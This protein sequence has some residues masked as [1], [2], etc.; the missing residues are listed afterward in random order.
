[1]IPVLVEIGILPRERTCSVCGV[2]CT[3]Q[4]YTQ[5][6]DGAVFRCRICRTRS[7]LRRGTFFDNSKLPLSS[8]MILLFCFV[9]GMSY[10]MHAYHI[11]LESPTKTG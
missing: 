9:T 2:G 3:L 8:L 1:M 5:S 6:T 10:K 11:S 7:S 4:K